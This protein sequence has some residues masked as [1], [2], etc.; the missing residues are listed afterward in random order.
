MAPDGKVSL[1]IYNNHKGS[2]KQLFH[3]SKFRKSK[4]EGGLLWGGKVFFNV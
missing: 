2:C 4:Y 3:I 1:Y